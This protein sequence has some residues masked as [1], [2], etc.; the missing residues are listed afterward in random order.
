MELSCSRSLSPLET[1]VLTDGNAPDAGHGDRPG[2]TGSCGHSFRLSGRWPAPKPHTSAM[3]MA[4]LAWRERHLGHTARRRICDEMVF[5][6]MMQ[7]ADSGLSVAG[8]RANWHVASRL[9]WTP[10]HRAGISL[11]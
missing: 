4:H 1:F 9:G 10:L 5:N 2:E 7:P 3:I 8:F 6:A 11:R